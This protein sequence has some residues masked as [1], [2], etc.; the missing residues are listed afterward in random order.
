MKMLL[1]WS[2]LPIINAFFDLWWLSPL[3]VNAW[4]ETPR[5]KPH[6][7]PRY[8]PCDTESCALSDRWTYL[9]PPDWPNATQSCYNGIRTAL[10][11]FHNTMISLPFVEI[12]N[13]TTCKRKV[14]DMYER[15]GNLSRPYIGRD[16]YE[17][18][19][20]FTG[21]NRTLCETEYPDV[22]GYCGCFW[23][24][25]KHWAR[26][27]NVLKNPVADD[28]YFSVED[29]LLVGRF[30]INNHKINALPSYQQDMVLTDTCL[31]SMCLWMEHLSDPI[32]AEK[33]KA[34]GFN[35]PRECKKLNLPYNLIHCKAIVLRRPYHPCPWT[36][37]IEDF[38]RSKYKEDEL[39][40]WNDNNCIPEESNYG[41]CGYEGKMRCRGNEIM[42]EEIR[43]G[44]DMDFC[45][46]DPEGC[47]A[48]TDKEE[49]SNPMIHPKCGWHPTKNECVVKC[50]ER[51]CSVM[52]LPYVNQHHGYRDMNFTYADEEVVDWDAIENE[53][54]SKLDNTIPQSDQG[55]SEMA[56]IAIIAG[57]SAVFFIILITIAIYCCGAFKTLRKSDRR[58]QRPKTEELEYLGK[59]KVI[60]KCYVDRK[61]HEGPRN[62]NI[63]KL[64][65]PNKYAK[66]IEN[67]ADGT[68]LAFNKTFRSL[69]PNSTDFP[70]NIAQD[71]SS[72]KRKM[73]KELERLEALKEENQRKRDEADSKKRVQACVEI[74]AD[75]TI[76]S[77]TDMSEKPP[78]ELDQT[79]TKLLALM[80]PP[81]EKEPITP[82]TALVLRE[83]QRRNLAR[84]WLTEEQIKERQP[85]PKPVPKGPQILPEWFQYKGE[86]LELAKKLVD[87]KT[88]KKPV[89]QWYQSGQCNTRKCIFRHEIW[90]PGDLIA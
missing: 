34:A 43:C 55:M 9:G 53:D 16:I 37:R 57:L 18:C 27:K 77:L 20:Y 45:C 67:E 17:G 84:G 36:V 41:C 44:S 52:F 33:S 50:K 62:K 1:I 7:G 10:D 81:R 79:G 5:Y 88:G 75:E 56:Y 11:E 51:K 15:I 12:F 83:T 72:L 22:E 23:N 8:E 40:C 87:P 70:V 3:T 90:Q 14:C 61:P 35:V 29:Y 73:D 38:S 65:A 85:K 2:V 49:C 74:M 68:Q 24:G 6:K 63:F 71:T 26:N 21:W 42:C 54:T 78:Q 46:A 89:C 60:E 25:R 82:E 19:E 39:F 30:L 59:I 4:F 32:Y 48:V 76:L 64:P 80:P 28:C 69:K 31:D 58:I 66:K 47:A 13:T 86:N